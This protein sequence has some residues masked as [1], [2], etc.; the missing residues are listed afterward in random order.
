MLASTAAIAGPAACR[1]GAGTAAA[2]LP[3]QAGTYLPSR[4][5]HGRR[6]LRCLAAAGGGSQPWRFDD[7]TAAPSD[8]TSFDELWGQQL[9]AMQRAQDRMELQR[10]EMEQ[11]FEAVQQEAQAA[12]ASGRQ[13]VQ[14][15]SGPCGYHW[16]RSYARNG[17]G[18]QEYRSESYSVIGV[19]PPGRCGMMHA[20]PPSALHMDPLSSLGLLLAAALAGFWVAATAAFNRRFSLTTYREESRWRLLL[21]WPLLL[22]TSAEFRE[23]FWA[24][25]RG[26]RPGA[27]GDAFAAGGKQA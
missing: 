19:P 17:P 11:R 13:A 4:R 2:H 12:G 9:K 8:M 5:Q 18:Y 15:H 24:A 14:E 6:L 27:G 20:P 26:R 16:Q 10:R 25:V 3:Q 7:L 1:L 23:Q 21:L 22:L